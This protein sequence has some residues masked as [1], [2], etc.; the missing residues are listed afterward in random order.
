M[1]V[2]VADSCRIFF[3]CKQHNDID[4]LDCEC[5]EHHCPQ[6]IWCWLGWNVTVYIK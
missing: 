6:L 2:E 3:L 5:I 1:D 4:V